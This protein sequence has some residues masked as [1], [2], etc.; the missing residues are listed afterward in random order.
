LSVLNALKWSF[1]GE[2][3]SKAIQPIV[4][5]VLARLL[6]PEDFGVMTAALMVIGFSQIFWEAGMGK[7]L[8]QRQTDI[9]D[10][11]NAAFWINVVLGIVISACLYFSSGFVAQ[12]FFQDKRVE[13][14][15]QVMTVQIM[16]GAVSSVHSALMQKNMNFK[17]LFWI[18][19]ATVSFP[20]MASIPLAWS[21]MGYWALVA[22]S[23]VGQ[24]VQVLIIFCVSRWSPSAAFN[25][26]VAK[27][28]GGFGVWVGV[29]G[30]MGWLFIWFDSFVVGMFL[31]SH[32]L[33]LYRMGTLFVT[34]IFSFLFGPIIPVC[35][36]HISAKCRDFCTMR[37]AYFSI[38]KS[39]ACISV[40][41][42]FF[43][44]VNSDFIAMSIFENKWDGID[45][46][47]KASALI[48]CLSWTVCMNG[49]FYRASGK[50]RIE[51]V[52]MLLSAILYVPIYFYT[53]RY[54]IEGF[55]YGRIF[56]T[57]CGFMIQLFFISRCFNISIINLLF[58][59]LFHV[60]MY[61]FVIFLCT[62]FLHENYYIIYYIVTNLFLCFSCVF[63]AYKYLS[64]IIK[65]QFFT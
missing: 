26:H 27:E 62:V 25:K 55:V 7:A 16:L 57:F 31:G 32:E 35:Y 10:A 4:F 40:P 1:L 24:I 39:I 50:P 21:G 33:G 18:R 63:F 2:L 45:F 29:S 51:T 11:A 14:V 60:L 20:G 52:V 42:G 22:G 17:M 12:T 23:L 41:V 5:I 65:K 43:I 48:N 47:I 19:F 64:P 9:E 6:M 58:Y 46:I 30:L 59:T 38:I 36:S 3:A 28:L 8:I 34:M 61:S 13:L 53:I 44:Y 56:A 49:E 15:L 37:S 54:G